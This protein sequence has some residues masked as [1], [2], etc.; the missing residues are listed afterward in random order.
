MATPP[1]AATGLPSCAPTT[2][3]SDP[4][5]NSGANGGVDFDTPLAPHQAAGLMAGEIEREAAAEAG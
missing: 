3:A 5:A 4:A 2:A 1:T